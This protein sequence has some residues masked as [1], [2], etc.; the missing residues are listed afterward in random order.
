MK[1][2]KPANL[3]QTDSYVTAL[4]VNPAGNAIVSAH[5]DGSIYTFWFDSIERGA[6][7]IA[8]HSCVPFALSWGASIVVAGN[9]GQVTF[10]DEDGGENKETEKEVK[11]VC[12]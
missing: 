1:T 6:H 9:D 11:G 3:Y 12:Y 5:L 7:V 8:R 2:H 10:Y 4:C